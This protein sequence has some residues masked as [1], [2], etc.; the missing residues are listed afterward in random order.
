MITAATST[1]VLEQIEAAALTRDYE[2]SDAQSW[3]IA[4]NV[5][6]LCA[7]QRLTYRRRPDPGAG[8]E[9]STPLRRTE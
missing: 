9:R 3:Q 5:V 8:R 2:P 6:L 1:D 4:V 7:G